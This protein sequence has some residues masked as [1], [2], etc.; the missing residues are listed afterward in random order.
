MKENHN[1]QQKP[2]PY[3][4]GSARR[5]VFSSVRQS[6][7]DTQGQSL[8]SDNSCQIIRFTPYLLTAVFFCLL[9][10]LPDEPLSGNH[11]YQA[12]QYIKL[13]PGFEYKATAGATFHA[14]INPF[15]LFPPEEGE[16][17]GPGGIVGNGGVV[18]STAGT[19]AVSETGQA[20]YAIPLEFPG[21]IAGMTP[22]ISLVYNSNGSD[23]I[24]GPGWSLGGLSVINLVPANRYSDGITKTAYGG[25]YT[26]DAYTLDGQRLILVHNDGNN[27]LTFKTEQDVFSKIMRSN[28]PRDTE[29]RDEAGKQFEVKTKSGLTYFYG[30]DGYPDSR[31]RHKIETNIYTVAY[32]VNRIVDNFDNEIRFT[33]HSIA[34][35]ADENLKGEI[36]ID[37]ITYTSNGSIDPMYRIKFDYR[38][39]NSPHITYYSYQ[40]ANSQVHPIAFQTDKLI[41]A[42]TCFYEPDDSVVKKY[43]L[44]YIQNPTPCKH[45]GIWPEWRRRV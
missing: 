25:D 45:T 26:Q 33:Y 7:S 38:A 41:D 6:S 4:P 40:P 16:T 18:G 31:L 30:E 14:D 23:G 17:G 29:A 8:S 24:L 12:S 11:H 9:I 22:D 36:Y 21:G 2:G 28:I 3:Q 15:L 27:N 19:F 10:S 37:E 34:G 13:K 20:T 39:R 44:D 35:D 43:A 1:T 5:W 32:Y 42:I